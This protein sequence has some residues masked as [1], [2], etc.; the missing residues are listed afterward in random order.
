MSVSFA[1]AIGFAIDF[2]WIANEYLV[3][4]DGDGDGDSK[5]Y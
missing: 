3:D 2:R 4:S 5:H 1:I